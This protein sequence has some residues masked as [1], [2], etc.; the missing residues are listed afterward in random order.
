MN[1]EPTPLKL[2]TITATTYLSVGVNTLFLA[3]FVDLDDSCVVCVK[4][5]KSIRSL[6]I[7][8][9][10]KNTNSKKSNRAFY[11]QCT[12]VIRIRDDKII[13]TKFFNNGYIHMTGCK[14]LE[15]G[16]RTLEKILEILKVQK[17][18]EAFD[19]KKQKKFLLC[20]YVED[21]EKVDIK[22]LRIVLINT[23]FD[24]RCPI[25]RESLHKV[26]VEK[27]NLQSKLDPLVYV[28]VN[29]KYVTDTGAKVTLLLFRTGKVIISYNDLDEI[30]K[31]YHFINKLIRENYAEVRCEPKCEKE[32]NN[33]KKVIFSRKNQIILYVLKRTNRKTKTGSELAND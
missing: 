33:I 32:S 4:Y 10:L 30:K 21:I 6:P 14:T 1:I 13:E 5:G 15:D 26:L 17:V 7:Y 16:P 20:K 27:Y 3:K 23:G 28:A 9:T 8:E 2:Y 12:L 25:N 11:N 18:I 29:V 19:E 31:A 22:P 24:T